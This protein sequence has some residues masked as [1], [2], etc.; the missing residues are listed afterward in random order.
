MTI[1]RRI[2]VNLEELDQIIDRST[3]APLRADA[4]IDSHRGNR[5]VPDG[6]RRVSFDGK[7]TDLVWIG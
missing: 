6:Q 5:I 7:T 2:D 4:T 1:R 3:Q